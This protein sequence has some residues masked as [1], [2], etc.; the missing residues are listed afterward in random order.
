[1]ADVAALAGDER[2]S[3]AIARI[4]ENVVGR[5]LHLTGGCGARADG[6]AYGDDYELPSNCYNE[7]CG[8]R[9]VPVLDP[10]HVPD[11]RQREVHGRVRATLYNGELSGVSLSGD[12]FFYPNTLEYDGKAKNN[13]GFAG[14]A[15][16]FGCS[17]CPPNIMRMLASLGGYFYAV[18]GDNLFVN[19]YASGEGTAT[20]AGNPVKLEQVTRYPWDGAVT[21]RVQ[22]ERPADFTL[23]LRIPGWVRGQP[24]PSDLYT[25]DDPA[26]ADWSLRVNGKPF[27]AA[28]KSGFA[29]IARRW[30]A[31]DT[32]ALDLPMPVRRVAGNPKI[33]ASADRWRWSAARSCTPSRAWTTTATSRISFCLRRPTVHPVHRDVLLGGVTVLEISEPRGGRR[34]ATKAATLTAIPYAAWNNRG[35]SPMRVWLPREAVGVRQPGKPKRTVQ[36]DKPGIKA[37]TELAAT[38]TWNWPVPSR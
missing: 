23:N 25:Y 37:D 16:W 31:G 24:L 15:P 17:C 30:Q 12:R 26:P 1:M 35:L 2:Y 4:W 20:V 19:L 36:V 18:R 27:A 6:E 21:V 11:D 38:R 3:A 34:T 7:T 5:K 13:V 14:R 29:A 33:A 10:P 32:V 22:P 9:L 28:M 8:R